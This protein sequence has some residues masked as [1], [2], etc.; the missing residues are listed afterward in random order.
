MAR[1]GLSGWVARHY[2]ESFPTG[3]LV[4]NLLGCLLI[5][6]LYGLFEERLLVDPLLRTSILLGFLGAFTTFS[7]F[8]IQLFTLLRDGEFLYALLYVAVSNLAGLVLVWVGYVISRAGT[9]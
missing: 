5:G 3:T 1:Y 4:V 7:S 6:L 9:T 2:G 8:G